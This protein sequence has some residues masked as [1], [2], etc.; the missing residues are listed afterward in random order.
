MLPCSKLTNFCPT[1]VFRT[2]FFLFFHLLTDT[3]QSPSIPIKF[4]LPSIS[5]LNMVRASP[6]S[7]KRYS[8]RRAEQQSFRSARSTFASSPS[9]CKLLSFGC[10]TGIR[11]LGEKG[12]IDIEIVGRL[13]RDSSYPVFPGDTVSSKHSVTIRKRMQTLARRAS[14]LEDVA[15]FSIFLPP[16]PG[17]VFVFCHPVSTHR[18]RSDCIRYRCKRWWKRLMQ[19]LYNYDNSFSLRGHLLLLTRCFFLPSNVSSLE[20]RSLRKSSVIIWCN[21]SSTVNEAWKGIFA[22]D[23]IVSLLFSGLNEWSNL[24]GSSL[25][26]KLKIGKR[27]IKIHVD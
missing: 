9:P 20:T 3:Y 1:H 21:V 16:D 7:L 27:M 2:F 18:K 10:E 8:I 24:Q 26:Q 19:H 6:Q 14:F 17:R 15:S 13:N 11:R 25:N 4:Q 22:L 5:Y 23:F 12:G